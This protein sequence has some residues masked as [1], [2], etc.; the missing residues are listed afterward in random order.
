MHST[1]LFEVGVLATCSLVQFEKHLLNS[2]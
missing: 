1:L 2:D